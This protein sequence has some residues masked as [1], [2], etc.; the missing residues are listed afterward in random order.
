M[1][2]SDKHMQ[3]MIMQTLKAIVRLHPLTK[4]ARM[5]NIKHHLP[6]HFDMNVNKSSIIG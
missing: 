2:I 6:K 5:Q 3:K 1:Q 4:K